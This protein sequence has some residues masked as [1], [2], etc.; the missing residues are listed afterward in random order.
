MLCG[1][2]VHHLPRQLPTVRLFPVG[3]GGKIAA[4]GRSL[5]AIHTPGHTKGHYVFDDS[6]SKLLFSGDHILPHI[7]PSIGFELGPWGMPLGD[8]VNSL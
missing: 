5:E 3:T 1:R 2:A 4:D 6:E 7:T 8:Y